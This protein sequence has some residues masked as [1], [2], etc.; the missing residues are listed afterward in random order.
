[1]SIT[2]ETAQSTRPS[3]IAALVPVAA[4]LFSVSLLLMGNGLQGVLLPVR[5][6]AEEFSSSSI[7][8]M[9]SAYFIGFGIGCM[10]GS[11]ILRRVG[12][13][14]TFAAL[15]AIASA[16]PL[17]HGMFTPET[18]WWIARAGTG[19]CFAGLYMVI[20][21]W[22]NEKAT[23]AN[24][25]FVFSIYTII[26][27]TVIT[28]G[29]MLI[30]TA[31]TSD[32]FLFA[33]ASVLVSISAVP[34]AL[35]TASAPTP[36]AIVR[37]RL[38]HLYRISPVG[39]VGCFGIGLANGAFWSLAPV[40]AQGDA[41]DPTAAAIFMSIAVIAGAASQWPIGWMSDRTDRRHVI[42]AL[43]IGGAAAGFFLL[44]APA[45]S[46]TAILIAAGCF[47]VFAFPL[48]SICT[49]HLN[50][51]V[52]ADGFVEASS[53][54]LLVFAGGAVFGPIIA[55]NFM[56]WVGPE[57]LFGYTIVIHIA[58]AALALFRMTRRAGVSGDHAT[59]SEA[60]IM[61]QTM[62]DIDARTSSEDGVS[63]ADRESPEDETPPLH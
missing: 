17:I 41:Q 12:H 40:Y 16:L 48:Y 35:T 25:G 22:L 37:L 30:T 9:G 19:F 28:A 44:W 24:R 27:L 6:V 14:R 20:E 57:G 42:V 1:V 56:G 8:I 10:T 21:S 29:Q 5:A 15:V 39:V 54:L 55:S 58:V 50:D 4:L 3:A 32:L 62:T 49:A 2:P 59:F 11:H 13:I 26:N 47:G 34:I 7:G 33:L 51:F 36:P 38:G 46:P 60:V 31:G 43:C 45:I 61:S 63:D 23:N 53:G 18:V 52:E